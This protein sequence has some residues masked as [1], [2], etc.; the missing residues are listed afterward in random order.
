MGK[1][2]TNFNDVVISLFNNVFNLLKIEKV[3]CI[4]ALYLLYR[5]FYLVHTIKNGVDIDKLLIDT[6]IL[7][8]ILGNNNILIPVLFIVVIALIVIIF[9]F[10]VLVR[11]IYLSEI[12]RLT[13]ERKYLM[14]EREH[15]NMD[16]IKEHHSS[17]RDKNRDV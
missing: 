14:H 9:V 3:V 17:K 11:P 6:K 15:G 1:K 8:H 4:A 13:E 12:R 5:D 7:E 10:I 16:I 2:E